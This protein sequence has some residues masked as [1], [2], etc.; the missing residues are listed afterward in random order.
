MKKFKLKYGDRIMVLSVDLKPEKET[1]TEAFHA[2]MNSLVGKDVSLKKKL[3]N[4]YPVVYYHDDDFDELVE[5]DLECS[6]MPESSKCYELK[7][8]PNSS[9]QKITVSVNF[10]ENFK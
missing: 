1:E 4:F 2:R 6:I 3:D 5:V 9:P 8:V 10:I 7:F